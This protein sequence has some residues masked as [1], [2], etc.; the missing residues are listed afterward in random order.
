[1]N[2]SG[3]CQGKMR[4]HLSEIESLEDRICNGIR[5]FSSAN[6][7]LAVHRIV[8]NNIG[9]PS[10]HDGQYVE[11]P[12]LPFIA[13]ALCS[14]SIRV[15]NPDRYRGRDI[16][17]TDISELANLV[18]TYVTADPVGIDHELTNLFYES[19]PVFMLLRIVGNQFPFDPSSFGFVGQPL[20][21][22]GKIPSSNDADTLIK[23]FAFEDKFMASTGLPL[24]DFISCGFASWAFFNS[25]NT[26]GLTRNYYNE[27][28]RQGLNI[29]DD[30]GIS[31]WLD[32]I[33]AD[34]TRFRNK[35][36]VMRQHDR[37]FRM[38]DFNPILSYPILRPWKGVPKKSMTDDRIIAPLP[39]LI[40]YR[41][42]TGIY[43]EMFNQ[44]REEFSRFFGRIFEVYVGELLGK[45]VSKSSLYD[46]SDIRKTYPECR[47]KT[48]DFA[49]IDGSTV[50]L[51]ECKAT[52]FSLKALATGA[53]EAIRDSLKQVLKG[54]KQLYDF[55]VALRKKANGLEAFSTCDKVRPVLLTYERLHMV[56]TVFFRDYLN[57]LLKDKFGIEKFEWYVL[58]VGELEILQPFLCN[59]QCL[60]ETL[61]DIGAKPFN[62]VIDSYRTKA[63]FTYE[64][65]MLY[66]YDLEMFDR[67]NIPR[68]AKK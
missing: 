40:A 7:L 1:L 46:E 35:Y 20:L 29:L 12:L 19:N 24:S 2:K 16:T 17:P 42:S 4:D 49:I 62:D 48:P 50:I 61:G 60:S 8:K 26:M 51:I 41:V 22:Y 58:S 37:R 65:S 56:N 52:R 54:L 38:Y 9:L 59:G 21:L 63:H 44:Y 23:A 68:S 64:Q 57:V 45:C 5:R 66:Q 67:L 3:S 10:R 43:Y 25:T 14:Y 36:E 11:S 34:P 18:M 53:E 47:G 30:A 6:V 55:S 28:R 27:A 33:A 15:S 39:N 31:T 13:A 32:C